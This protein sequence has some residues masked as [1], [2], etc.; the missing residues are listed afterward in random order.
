METK[1]KIRVETDEYENKWYFNE[2]DQLH[3]INGP[4][5]DYTCGIKFWYQ[6]GKL[7]RI[8]GP[9]IEHPDGCKY[10]FQNG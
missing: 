1:E 5:I 9:A 2:Q 4:A 6:N 3:R 7:H 10:W 8:E